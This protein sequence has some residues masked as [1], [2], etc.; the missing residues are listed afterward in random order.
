MKWF[1][2][3]LFKLVKKGSDAH[4]EEVVKEKQAESMHH[5]KQFDG[6]ITFTLYRANGGHIVEYR[7]P[8]NIGAPA[9]IANGIIG[10]KYRGGDEVQASKLHIITADQDLG[11]QLAHIITYE[12]LQ[13]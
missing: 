9:N 8:Y 5:G 12:A 1:Y 4:A 10:S 11:Q 7:T 2:K 6:G 3:F 13:Q